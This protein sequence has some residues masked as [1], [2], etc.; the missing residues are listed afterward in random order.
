MPLAHVVISLCSCLLARFMSSAVFCVV[1]VLI[2]SYCGVLAVIHPMIQVY[3]ALYFLIRVIVVLAC[4]ANVKPSYRPTMRYPGGGLIMAVLLVTW[5]IAWGSRMALGGTPDVQVVG[6]ITVYVAVNHG[7]V[8]RIS[9]CEFYLLVI[10]LP[11]AMSFLVIHGLLENRWRYEVA[12][13]GG[14]CRRT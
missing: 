3:A 1:S 2:V 4:I 9:W 12:V 10:S 14:K 5:V 8:T 6:R 13:E 11:L 7:M